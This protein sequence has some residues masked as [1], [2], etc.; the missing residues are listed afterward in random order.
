MSEQDWKP[1]IFTKLPAK[2]LK[3]P[4]GKKLNI[5]SK[6]N[7][8]DNTEIDIIK[9][10]SNETSKAISKKRTDLKISQKDFAHEQRQDQRKR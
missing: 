3:K 6:L 9:K 10:V 5:G 7:K 8:L 4:A 1:V 2:N